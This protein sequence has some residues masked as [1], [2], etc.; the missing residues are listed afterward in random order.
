MD[1]L[2]ATPEQSS[3]DLS[4]IF[5]SL[6]SNPD[7]LS[8]VSGIIS[9]YT[10]SESAEKGGEVEPKID[11]PEPQSGNPEPPSAPKLPDLLSLFSKSA[12]S[13]NKEQTAL[14]LAIRP[15]LSEHRREL[16]DGFI[17]MSKLTDILKSLT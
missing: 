10:N 9:Q 17:K 8:R 15:Y 14:L 5:G 7:A 6:L 11:N 2:E 1:D 4:A 13:Q 16:I 12:P 3:A